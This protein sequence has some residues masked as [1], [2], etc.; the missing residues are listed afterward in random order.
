MPEPICSWLRSTEGTPWVP[1]ILTQEQREISISILQDFE[2][3]LRPVTSQ[4]LIA[5]V[6]SLLL[7]YH[8]PNATPADLAVMLTDWVVALDTLPAWAVTVA[9]QQYLGAQRFRP[10]P[11]DVRALAM[12]AVGDAIQTRDRLKAVLAV[13]PAEHVVVEALWPLVRQQEIRRSDVDILIRPLTV[14]MHTEYLTGRMKGGHPGLRNLRERDS[15]ESLLRKAADQLKLT[16]YYLVGPD[17]PEPVLPTP[18][19]REY[20][21]QEIKKFLSCWRHIA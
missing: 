7:H 13:P 2:V 15:T 20:R 8:T 19:E 1:P 11:H 3:Y 21:R 10:S 14:T 18:E 4:W 5:R 17:D 9:C 16:S 6:R 12:E